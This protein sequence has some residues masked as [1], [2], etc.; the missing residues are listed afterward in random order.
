MIKTLKS[1][2]NYPKSAFTTNCPMSTGTP[3]N[4]PKLLHPKWELIFA[5]YAGG[6]KLSWNVN[7]QLMTTQ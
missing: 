3:Y 6:E 4:Y 1:E 2:I 5:K 7:Q